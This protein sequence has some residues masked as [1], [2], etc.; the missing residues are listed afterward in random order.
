MPAP[1][2]LH[3]RR[4]RPAG[5]LGAPRPACGGGSTPSVAAA[6]LDGALRQ[7][8]LALRARP[9]AARRRDERRRPPPPRA[10]AARSTTS[11]ATRSTWPAGWPSSS[12]GCGDCLTGLEPATDRRRV[13]GRAARRR[14]STLA[15]VGGDDAWQLPQLERELARA[16]AV[17]GGRRAAE[18]RLADV[19]AL[20][21]SRL[22][23]DRPAPTSAPARSRSARWCRCARCRTAW[24][25]C[26]GLDDGVFPRRGTV[27]GDDVLGPAA[28]HRRARPAQ[29]G[30][31]AAPRRDAGRH[32]D[33]RDHLHRRQ[34]ALRGPPAARR[35]ARRA[36]RRRSTARTAAPVR[37]AASLVRHP[38]QP[39]DARNLDARRA[40]SAPRPFSFDAAALG[41][42]AAACVGARSRARRSSTA[43]C[44]PRPPRTSSL[45]DLQAF[46]CTRCARSCAAGSTSPR[47]SR[48][49][50]PPTRSR[51]T[52][53][54]WSSGQVG[55]RLLREVL[56]GADPVAVMT[57]EQ[58]RGG[59]PP[60]V[61]GRAHARARS[62][63]RPAALVAAPPAARRARRRS[64]D[65]DV[66]L[67]GGR[68]LTGTVPD[69]YGNRVVS[70]GYSRLKAKQRL[71]RLGRRARAQRRAPRRR[72]GP[73]TPS[74]GSAP[75]P[76][77]A[78]AGPLDHRARRLAARPGRRCATS[79]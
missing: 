24:S 15:D 6:V 50:R 39:F 3:R 77:R 58:L 42:A 5:P 68:R 53:T 43:R 11:A 79:G 57:A 20:L 73:A 74:A 30:P 27:D 36:A 25:A 8:H 1:V 19:R 4:P 51:S 13:D 9:G 72:A 59:L 2:R 75:G 48:P 54:R 31:P 33:A 38:L 49:T 71:Q 23:A 63:R 16:A 41:G 66:D 65:V 70:L 28:A 14:P 26:V 17:V 61:L 78:L 22:A 35:T 18:L 37:A 45:A 56:A 12:T 29:R 46:L 10:R 69:V 34:R 76:R 55:D 21:A 52:S 40:R 7:Q 44:P 64:L 32:R 67:G 60:G 47:R 62:P